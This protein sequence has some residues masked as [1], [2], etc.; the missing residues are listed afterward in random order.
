MTLKRIPPRYKGAIAGYYVSIHSFK[1]MVSGNSKASPFREA[2][3]F[4]AH[5]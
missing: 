4:N 2:L 1:T 5:H 3:L